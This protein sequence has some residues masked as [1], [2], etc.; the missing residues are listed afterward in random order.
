[1]EKTP[2]TVACFKRKEKLVQL[3][4]ESG[5][6]INQV[7]GIGDTPLEAACRGRNENI[8]QF[9]LNQGCDVEEKHLMAAYNGGNKKIYKCS[10]LKKKEVILNMLMVCQ[11][12]H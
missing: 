6:D 8:V 10:Y 7:D 3:L 12:H 5:C 1:M 4:I 9:L 2:F 11:R